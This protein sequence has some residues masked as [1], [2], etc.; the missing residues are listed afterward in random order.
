MISI[1]FKSH[2]PSKK[3][4]FLFSCC[5]SLA[6]AEISLF[7]SPY[8][9][10]NCNGKRPEFISLRYRY[11][12]ALCCVVLSRHYEIRFENFCSI[13]GALFRVVMGFRDDEWSQHS[14]GLMIILS[15][16]K[17]SSQS[18]LDVQ[19]MLIPFTVN[20]SLSPRPRPARTGHSR[21]HTRNTCNIRI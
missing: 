9:F 4:F 19:I 17:S 21:A 10:N 1:N 2:L 14:E 18:S 13:T 3:R 8:S 12:L 16:S 6:P 11:W 7:Y 5:L 15:H 20:F